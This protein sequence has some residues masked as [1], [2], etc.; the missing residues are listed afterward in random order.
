MTRKEPHHVI[1]V[2]M[3][4]VQSKERILEATREKCQVTHKSKPLRIKA[5]H[6]AEFLKAKSIWTETKITANQDYYIQQSHP[7]KLKEN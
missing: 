1:I 3:P 2:T 7:L 5:D 4:R 6:S